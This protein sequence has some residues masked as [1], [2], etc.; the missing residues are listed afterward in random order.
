[1]G[2][3]T[4]TEQRES[5]KT[6]VKAFKKSDALAQLILVGSMGNAN[7]EV[8]STCDSAKSMWD[9]LISIYELSS[10][11]RWIDRLM[12]QFF[13]FEKDP[14]EDTTHDCNAILAN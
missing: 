11:Q 12:E 9:K 6:K 10:G 7:V 5:F 8:T 14:S 1:M 13:T 2:I 4:T 3:A